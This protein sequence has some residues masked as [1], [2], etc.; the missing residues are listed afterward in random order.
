MTNAREFTNRLVDL[1][2]R[3]QGA[4][5]DF[6][7]ALAEFDR[8]RLWLELGHSSLFYFLHRELGLSKGAS[9]FRKTAAELV[10]RFPEVIEPLRDGRLCITSIVELAKV[11]TPENRAEILSRFFHCSKSEAKAVSAELLPSTAPHRDVVTEMRP[12]SAPSVGTQLPGFVGTLAV[13]L[14]EPATIAPGSLPPRP[15]GREADDRNVIEPVTADLR[16]FHV[17]VSRRLLEKLDAARA[18]LSHAKPGATAGEILEAGLD[19]LLAQDAKRK[20]LVAK[21]RKIAEPATPSEGSSTNNSGPSRNVPAA[22]KRAVWRRAGECCE[23]PLEGGGVCASTLRLELDHIVPVALGGGSTID[24]LR[25]LCR[26]HNQFAAR[27]VFG[28][29]WMDRYARQRGGSG[30]LPD[31]GAPT[32]T[33]TA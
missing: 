33:R 4:M 29:E 12:E 26:V 30:S 27:G 10:Q 15:R 19:L 23:W 18:A 28:D 20:A 13:H 32:R 16:R 6:L 17:T 2:R 3:E 14:D 11:I 25:V 21:P 7:V 24:N 8:K 9:H 5:A 31:G 22:V 1:L